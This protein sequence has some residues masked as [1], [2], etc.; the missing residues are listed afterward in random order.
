MEL[1]VQSKP[2]HF[3]RCIMQEVHFHDESA[4]TIVPDS[5]PDI[6]SILHAYADPI[7]RGKDCRNQS[8]TIAGGIKG[9]ILYL[10][11]KENIPRHLD[12]YI[13]FSI[14]LDH[15]E[16]TE[17]TKLVCSIRIR[18]VDAKIINSRKATL[19]VCLGCE[20][21]AYENVEETLYEVENPP[22]VLQT[23]TASYRIGLPLETTEKLEI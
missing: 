20:I 16:F 10:P 22:S 12:L 7:I 19:R 9:G 14:R 3:L 6:L 8:A 1:N 17:N 21:A 2:L 5:L 15:A 11:E 23:R 18:S 4:D 13:P